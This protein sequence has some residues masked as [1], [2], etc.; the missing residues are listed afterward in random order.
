MSTIAGLMRALA[1]FTRY[2]KKKKK[3]PRTQLRWLPPGVRLSVAYGILA[4][5]PD[6]LSYG[7]GIELG[8]SSFMN[9]MLC[10]LPEGRP[11]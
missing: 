2:Q 11:L 7:R 8:C 3:Y 1:M 5:V 10:N 6:Y 4:E 9:A